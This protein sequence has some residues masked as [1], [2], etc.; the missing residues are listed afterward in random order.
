MIMGGY[1]L[2]RLPDSASSTPLKTSSTSE[3]VIPSDRHSRQA[4]TS[5]CPLQWK[6]IPPDILDLI[7]PDEVELKDR[8]K[9]DS[10]TKL[11][12]IIQTLWFVIQCIA[13]GI[14]LLPLTELEIVTLAYA[15]MNF[16]IYIFWWDKPRNVECP[17]RLYKASTASQESDV[18]AKEWEDAWA[19]G[20]IQKMSSYAIGSQDIF[21]NL[22]KGASVPMFWSGRPEKAVFMNASVGPSLLGAAFGAIHCISWLYE[23]PSH[24]QKFLWHVSC[25]VMIA[26]PLLAAF[27]C[28][29]LRISL[30]VGKDG[31]I[32]ALAG[33]L[34]LVLALSAWLYILAR[35]ATLVI[36]FANLRSLSPADFSAVDWTYF[37]PHI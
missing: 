18:K 22:T 33:L 37:I 5:V 10:L 30:V 21:S 34:V 35:V 8:G 16:F 25:V 36:A 12:V 17:I 11:I 24:L 15:M 29:A 31:L 26:V 32:S 2:L 28:S 1:H 7:T 3:F 27:A 23:F 4:A 9:S 6:D 14:Q 20:A 13:R 19:I